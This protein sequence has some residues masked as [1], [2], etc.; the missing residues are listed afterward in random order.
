MGT[1]ILLTKNLKLKTKNLK[2][3]FQFLVSSFQQLKTKNLKLETAALLLCIVLLMIA[4]PFPLS[5][6]G[7]GVVEASAAW[8]IEAV[9]APKDSKEF[10]EVEIFYNGLIAFIETKDL[11]WT[12]LAL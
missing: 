10:W 11:K 6:G 5:K 12:V 9:E 7:V 4:L 2:G 3:S 1:W 8:T